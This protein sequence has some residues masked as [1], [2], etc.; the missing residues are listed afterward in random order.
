M[1]TRKYHGYRG[2][3]YPGGLNRPPKAYM[4]KGGAAARRVHPIDGKIVLLSVGMSNASAE[5]SAFKRSSDHDPQINSSVVVVDGAQDGYDATRL[6]AHPGYWD[7][8]DA[9]LAN[10]GVSADQVQAMWLKEAIAGESRRFPRDARA[11]QRALRT[12]IRTAR[13]RYPNLQL[14][15]V[16]SRTYGGYAITHF[17]ENPSSYA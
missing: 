12:I 10:A 8:V 1:G 13:L 11:L 6:V 17:T 16:S 5:F 4:K 15:Y 7:N 2:G 3:L 9:R 14:I